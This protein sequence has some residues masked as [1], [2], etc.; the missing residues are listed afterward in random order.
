[1]FSTFDPLP[2]AHK[3]IFFTLCAKSYFVVE[4]LKI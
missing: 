2:L 4:A 3:I 1:M